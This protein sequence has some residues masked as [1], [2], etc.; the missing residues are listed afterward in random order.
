MAKTSV[1][2][3]QEYRQLIQEFHNVNQAEDALKN[4]L[5][6]NS[7]NIFSVFDEDKI[8]YT[9]EQLFDQVLRSQRHISPKDISKY[10][11]T[12]VNWLESEG[13]E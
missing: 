1:E 4:W 7:P 10:G 5:R 6:I 13:D 8:D 3:L 2:L 9:I 11:R 12:V